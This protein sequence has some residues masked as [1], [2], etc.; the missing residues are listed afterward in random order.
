MGTTDDADVDAF[1]LLI[2]DRAA[3]CSGGSD[4]R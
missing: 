3:A 1:G 4:G 2:G